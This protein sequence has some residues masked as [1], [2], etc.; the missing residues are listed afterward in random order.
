MFLV[1]FLQFC[2]VIVGRVTSHTV[3]FMEKDRSKTE[4]SDELT[5]MVEGGW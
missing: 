2:N 1:A 4:K 3:K 5:C